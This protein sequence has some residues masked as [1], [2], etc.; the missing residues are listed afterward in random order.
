MVPAVVL[1]AGRSSRMGRAKAT[2]PL[3]AETFVARIVRTLKKGGADDVV[4]VLG[5]DADRIRSAMQD[6]MP[7]DVR[8]VTN[9]DWER[10]QLTSLQAGLAV[11][12]RPGVRALLVTL[13]DVPFVSA[14]TV[15]A[16]LARYRDTGAAIVRP[17][18]GSRHG[19]PIVIDRSLFD[20][21]RSA[22]PAAGAKAVVRAA[23]SPAGDVPV[24]DEGAFVD[25]DTPDEY[26]RY[27]SRFTIAPGEEDD[28]ARAR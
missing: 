15:R 1:A 26:R 4:V 22:D 16:V 21:L 27:L 19:H 12:D 23:A 18:S 11:V 25:V 3:G 10:G 6:A 13:V 24:E 2:L 8:V 7:A 9:P 17:V 14:D 20:A 5:H 28:G